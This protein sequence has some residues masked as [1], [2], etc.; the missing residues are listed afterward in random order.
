MA[1]TGTIEAPRPTEALVQEALALLQLARRQLREG[2]APDTA[3]LASLA[4]LLVEIGRAGNSTRDVLIGLQADLQMLAG[5]LA[6][7]LETLRERLETQARHRS[8]GQAYRVLPDRL[9]R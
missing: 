9:P 4:R 3:M 6:T 7:A 1:E 2:V 8:A 5:E